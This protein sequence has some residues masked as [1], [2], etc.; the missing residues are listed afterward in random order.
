MPAP[1]VDS[2]L[3][4]AARQLAEEA[5]ERSRHARRR[6]HRRPVRPAPRVVDAPPGAGVPA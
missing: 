4:V 2:A 6:H 3:L 1:S 5:L